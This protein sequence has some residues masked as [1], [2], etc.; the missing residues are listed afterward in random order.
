MVS[1][2]L[3]LISLLEPLGRLLGML[4]F[5]DQPSQARERKPSVMPPDA[6]KASIAGEALSS[7]H[8]TYRRAWRKALK[9]SNPDCKQS[10]LRTQAH[11]ASM[12]STEPTESNP[13]RPA[14]LS[15]RCCKQTGKGPA[16]TIPW[17][18]ACST[19]TLAIAEPRSEHCDWNAGFS[20]SRLPS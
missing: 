8:P 11:N 12:M 20:D 15:L 19:R 4:L 16:V 14:S 13:P 7:A 17:A 6:D 9:P 10:G 2:S 3:P 18:C 5:G 1:V